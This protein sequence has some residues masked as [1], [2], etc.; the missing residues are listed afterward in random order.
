MDLFKFG[1]SSTRPEGVEVIVHTTDPGLE[2]ANPTVRN[3]GTSREEDSKR[4]M[5]ER[6]CGAL[7][8]LL[9][10]NAYSVMR[11]PMFYS[12]QNTSLRDNKRAED[13]TVTPEATDGNLLASIVVGL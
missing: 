11:H 13:P 12:S 4:D 9:V 8:W 2:T 10:L 1:L 6:A 5:C 3:T 7:S